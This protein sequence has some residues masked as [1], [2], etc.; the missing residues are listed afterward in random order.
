[1][2]FEAV[3]VA[4]LLLAGLT[5][6]AQALESFRLHLIRQILVG[7]DFC[8]RHGDGCAGATLLSMGGGE[9]ALGTAVVRS[10]ATG[11]R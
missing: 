6:P 10:E 8:A 4:A 2:A 7:P 11:C 1:M 3:G 5:V 9:R